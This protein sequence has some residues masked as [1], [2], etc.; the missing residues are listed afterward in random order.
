MG[1][2]SFE[3]SLARTESQFV[4]IYKHLFLFCFIAMRPNCSTITPAEKVGCVVN[5]NATVCALLGCCWNPEETNQTLKCYTK[6]YVNFF[7]QCLLLA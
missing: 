6:G 7:F 1:T 2:G 3:N 5:T 4:L